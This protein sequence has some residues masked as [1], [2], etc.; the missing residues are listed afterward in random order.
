MTKKI[1]RLSAAVLL[2]SAAVV[3]CKNTP[4]EVAVPQDSTAADTVAAAT[5]AAKVDSVKPDTAKAEEAKAEEVKVEKGVYQ[6]TRSKITVRKGPG[7]DSKAVPQ[8]GWDGPSPGPVC[9]SSGDYLEATGKVENGY[10]QVKEHFIEDQSESM[11]EGKYGWVPVDCLKR[12][13]KCPHAHMMAD[14]LI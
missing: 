2:A 3:S 5:D 7:E 6:V 12:V 8:F 14:G 11:W 1:V 10:A 4:A 9:L 13:K